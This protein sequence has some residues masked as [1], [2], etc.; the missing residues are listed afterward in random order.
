MGLDMY[1]LAETYVSNW[2]FEIERNGENQRFN[3]TVALYPEIKGLVT[4]SSPYFTVSFNVG[5]W[6]KDN[7]IHNWF[8]KECGGG[9]D[10]CQRIHV[11]REKLVELRDLCKQV[12][13]QPALAS[14]TLPTASG[15]FFG[16]TDYDEWYLV[17]V[18]NTI[19]ML[20]KVL[21][22]IPDDH[23]WSFIYQAS[24]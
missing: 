22:Q 6:R 20:D 5:Y 15:F 16:S 21:K 14:S 13:K 2:N 8:V 23:R 1:L 10:E 3:D 7:Q 19:K 18:K 12:I 17:G 9:V 24:W 4:D 11:P